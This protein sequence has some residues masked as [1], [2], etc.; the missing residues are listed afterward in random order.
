MDRLALGVYAGQSLP[1]VGHLNEQDPVG[2]GRQLIEVLTPSLVVVED[3]QTQG[4]V[5]PPEAMNLL[6][7][8]SGRYDL[9]PGGRGQLGGVVDGHGVVPEVVGEPGPEVVPPGSEVEHP[10]TPA[11]PQ[12][13]GDSPVSGRTVPQGGPGL[14]PVDPLRLIR[15]YTHPRLLILDG[16]SDPSH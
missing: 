11:S 5:E 9:H 2:D 7:L 12:G 15:H 13:I 1:G 10:Q 8:Q 16:S 14:P 3:R 4:D 6:G